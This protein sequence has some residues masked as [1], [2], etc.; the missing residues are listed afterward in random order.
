MVKLFPIPH[1]PQ[2]SALHVHST[3]ALIRT[4]RNI[5]A[6]LHSSISYK[7]LILGIYMNEILKALVSLFF[8]RS[9]GNLS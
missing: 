4:D 9:A 7:F 5:F 6:T 2:S 3:N 1:N 8:I